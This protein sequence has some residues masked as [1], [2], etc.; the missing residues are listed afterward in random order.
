MWRNEDPREH[1]NKRADILILRPTGGVSYR[2][3]QGQVETKHAWTIWTSFE[4]HQHIDEWDPLWW[5]D[6][7]PRLPGA[8]VGAGDTVSGVRADQL[9]E[10][11]HTLTDPSWSLVQETDR[12]GFNAGVALIDSRGQRIALIEQGAYEELLQT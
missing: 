10:T 11:L 3:G 8:I 7:A 4:D 9:V 6:W 1:I 5:W 2:V 12:L